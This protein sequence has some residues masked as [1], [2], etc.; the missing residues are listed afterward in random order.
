MR[1][2]FF[3]GLPHQQVHAQFFHSVLGGEFVHFPCS[4]DEN[5]F[6]DHV[7]AQ[8]G[9]D[10][11][12][13]FNDLFYHLHP[14]LKGKQVLLGHGLGFM[15]NSV[16]PR[17]V[18]CIRHHI[19]RV[20]S[21]GVTSQMYRIRAGVPESL[22][23]PVGYTLVFD[24]PVRPV[25]PNTILFS[26][27]AHI[28]WNHYENLSR[29]LE[30][31]DQSLHGYVTLHPDTP[32]QWRRI[33]VE[34]CRDRPNLTYLETNEQLMEA[35]SFCAVNVGGGISSL[36]TVFWYLKK[37][38]ILLRGRVSRNPFKGLGWQRIKND[39]HTPLFN[40][41]LDESDKISHWKQFTKEL[42]LKARW[43]PSSQ[44]MFYPWNF[45]REATILKIKEFVN[46]LESGDSHR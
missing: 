9:D 21:T 15:G 28:G 46:E 26:S 3:V 40:R 1:Y 27:T 29:I 34:I 35:Y 43:A 13:F 44:E 12:W 19:D 11:I 17:R 31:L 32:E 7:M 5:N 30:R 45:D 4:V 14:R 33:F 2:K 18:E 36:S 42:V 8:D 24:I 16:T 25:K 41:V 38:V 39:A 37:P 23:R 6:P 22:I 10:V 20:F